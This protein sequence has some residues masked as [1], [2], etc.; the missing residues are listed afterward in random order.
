MQY[1]EAALESMYDTGL[2]GASCTVNC[3][4]GLLAV[5]CDMT[6]VLPERVTHWLPLESVTT[7]P[8]T[9]GSGPPNCVRLKDCP[10]MLRFVVRVLLPAVLSVTVTNRL[11]CPLVTPLVWMVAL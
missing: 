11:A 3:W 7:F 8:F 9:T 2:P 6:S 1:P 4:S 5:H 10:A